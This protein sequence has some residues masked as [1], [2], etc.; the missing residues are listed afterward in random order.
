MEKLPDDLVLEIL[1]L[2]INDQDDNYVLLYY[3]DFFQLKRVCKYWK[4]LMYDFS[5]KLYPNYKN[6]PTKI[7]KNVR[8]TVC[9]IL[10]GK[11]I[12]VVGAL[13]LCKYVI[14]KRE[15]MKKILRMKKYIT[16]TKYSLLYSEKKK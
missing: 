15:L 12:P 6:I 16:Q 7:H 2:T 8:L 5:W 4:Q 11:I 9:E 10:G 3:T 14:Y 13:E 1:Y